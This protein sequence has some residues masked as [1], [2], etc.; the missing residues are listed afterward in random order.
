[1]IKS[2]VMSEDLLDE[3]ASQDETLEDLPEEYI[4]EEN[5]LIQKLSV[6]LKGY[7][8]KR[9]SQFTQSAVSGRKSSRIS[10]RAGRKKVVNNISI[11][12]KANMPG[13]ENK[14]VSSSK[15]QYD[16]AKQ[17]RGDDERSLLNSSEKKPL[18][19]DKVR[20]KPF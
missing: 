19:K 10:S 12:K 3:E 18:F 20:A 13:L 8:K 9:V 17:R 15:N 6:A 5:P 11:Q 1:M 7:K 2:K 4:I 16:I 14:M